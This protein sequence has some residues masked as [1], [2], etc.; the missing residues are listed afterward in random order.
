MTKLLILYLY[1]LGILYI[2]VGTLFLVV[3]EIIRKK[4]I[5][6]IKNAPTKKI[7]V[8]P[9]VLGVLLL[10]AAPYNKYVLLIILLGL[11]ALAKGIAGI[12]ATEKIEKIHN[13]LFEKA[14]RNIYRI[15]GIAIIVLGSVVLM[16]I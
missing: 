8:I 13:W 5:A 6:K 15:W 14:N 9:I 3:P 2:A 10:L 16:G 1:I 12:V 7:S 11:L 4:W